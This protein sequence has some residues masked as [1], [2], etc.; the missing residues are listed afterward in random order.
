MGGELD[1]DRFV[2]VDE[3]GWSR[4]YLEEEDTWVI[5]SRDKDWCI[6][7]GW[8]NRDDCVSIKDKKN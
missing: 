1:V 7:W 4:I 5:E 6:I 3:G 8:F 2:G